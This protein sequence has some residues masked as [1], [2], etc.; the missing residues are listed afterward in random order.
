MVTYP[1]IV[2]ISV[3]QSQSDPLVTPQQ[4]TLL[5]SKGM[6]DFGEDVVSLGK[7]FSSKKDKEIMKKGTKRTGEGTIK[8]VPALNQVIWKTDSPDIK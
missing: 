1:I 5:A 6:A 4:D 7:Y 8:Q 2:E 3:S